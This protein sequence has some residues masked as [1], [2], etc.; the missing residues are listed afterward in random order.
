MQKLK[1]H[2]PIFKMKRHYKLLRSKEVVIEKVQDKYVLLQLE[3]GAF[4]ELNDTAEIIW[5]ELAEPVIVED[6]I[7][8]LKKRFSSEILEED[9]IIFL[10]K[11]MDKKL[12]KL[13]D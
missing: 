13:V 12:V 6:L 2:F 9:C 7:S 11:L 3:N 10:K 8:S 4:F 1:A 5:N